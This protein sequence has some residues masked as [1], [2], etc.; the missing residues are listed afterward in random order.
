VSIYDSEKEQLEV[1]KKWWQENG[2]MVIIG[3]ALGLAAVFAWTSWRSYIT[4]QAEEASARYNQLIASADDEDYLVVKRQ[5]ETILDK[6]PDRGYAP[7]TALVL[8]NRAAMEEKTEDAKRY[9]RWVME[10]AELLGLQRVAR[11]RL[12]RVLL[13][14][15]AYEQAL[16]LLN[17]VEPSTFQGPYAEIRG[18]ILAAQGKLEEARVAYTKALASLPATGANHDRVQMKLDELGAL[19]YPEQSELEQDTS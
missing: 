16:S 13:D 19:T 14:E 10:H 17:E 7:L 11:L 5:G 4:S 1:I 18:D 9:L 12:A 2:R 3:V 15:Q 8:A 6:F